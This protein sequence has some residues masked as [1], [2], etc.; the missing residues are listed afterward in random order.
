MLISLYKY[1]SPAEGRN[2]LRKVSS[3]LVN[4]D[5][6]L[7]HIVS[8][9]IRFGIAKELDKEKRLYINE[10]SDRLGKVDRKIVAFHLMTLEDA[11]LVKTYIEMKVPQKGNPVAV[12]YA[13]LT[14]RG[15]QVLK[16]L[17]A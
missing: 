9:P 10:L 14:E 13:E 5:V 2:K 17:G 8:H 3:L 6:K 15:K 12:R 1:Y 11:G 7:I 4:D 16:R